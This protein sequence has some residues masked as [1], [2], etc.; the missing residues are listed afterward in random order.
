MSVIQI[1]ARCGR[2][3]TVVT[4]PGQWCPSCR[5][6]LLSPVRPDQPVPPA[7]RNFRWVA[8]RPT[9]PHARPSRAASSP[10]GPT[11]RYTEPPRWGL[12]DPPPA[13]PVEPKPKRRDTLADL[14]GP[15]LVWTA[16]V[17]A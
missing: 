8:R 2:H 7:Q 9:N 15:L 12:L 17:F 1:C 3:W 14:A 5:G 6:V 4:V 10:P 13:D 16:V 11:P